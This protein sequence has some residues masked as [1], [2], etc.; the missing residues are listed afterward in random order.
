MESGSIDLP[1][2]RPACHTYQQAHCS[3]TNGY[4]STKLMD[5]DT[6]IFLCEVLR[7]S[8]TQSSPRPADSGAHK[9]A[10]RPILGLPTEYTW[11]TRVRNISVIVLIGVPRTRRIVVVISILSMG[12]SIHNKIT[13]L[14]L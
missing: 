7:K 4:L 5:T 10:E 8:Q 9:P 1:I 6:P 12:L 11:A 3:L 14:S 2:R 13:K